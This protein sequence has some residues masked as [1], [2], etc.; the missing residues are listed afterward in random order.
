MRP[1][2]NLDVTVALEVTLGLDLTGFAFFTFLHLH[3]C[4]I[5]F[6]IYY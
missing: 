4:A 6:V 5:G 3:F 1:A 2:S